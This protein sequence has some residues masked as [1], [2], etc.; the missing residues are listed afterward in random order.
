MQMQRRLG[1]RP[2]HG[3]QQLLTPFEDTVE[4]EHVDQPRC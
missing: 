2:A 4:T 3:P 1:R